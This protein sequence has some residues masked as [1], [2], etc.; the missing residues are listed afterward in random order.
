MKTS[1]T[2]SHRAFL[3]QVLDWAKRCV[4]LLRLKKAWEKGRI[5]KEEMGDRA[6]HQEEDDKAL[7][8]EIFYEEMPSHAPSLE[9]QMRSKRKLAEELFSKDSTATRK[10]LSKVEITVY[11]G[12]RKKEEPKELEKVPEEAAVDPSEE[13]TV[14]N[15]AVIPESIPSVKKESPPPKPKEGV[16]LEDERIYPTNPTILVIDDYKPLREMLA[17]ALKG[18][19]YN[20]CSAE[21]GIQGIVR[22]H[23]NVVDLI[24]TDVQMPKLD[25]FEMSKMLNV[26]DKTRD[27]PVI[28]LTEVLDEENQS[29]CQTARCGRY[30]GQALHHGRSV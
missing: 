8:E 12:S 15:A 14:P 21:D 23:E 27:I 11:G 22:I 13:E 3:E 25:G 6:I 20:V 5:P 24:I 26:R 10:A 7:V 17:K 18:A 28:F 16:S 2:K 29:H 30:P 1:S 9:V 19:N 4:D